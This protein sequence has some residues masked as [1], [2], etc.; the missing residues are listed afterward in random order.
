MDLE[1]YDVWWIDFKGPFVSTFGIKYDLGAV[2]YVSKWVELVTL[3]NNEERSV[4]NFAKKYSFSQL[5]MPHQIIVMVDH[6]SVIS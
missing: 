6:T 2:D 4:T 3:K 1:L 5:G